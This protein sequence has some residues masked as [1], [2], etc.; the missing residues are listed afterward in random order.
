MELDKRKPNTSK[1]V[2]KRN[3][4]DKI[5]IMSGVFNGVTTGTPISMMIFNSDCISKDYDDIKDIYRPSH[6]DYTYQKKYD[7]RD[8]RGGGRSS[9][10]E[11]V[12]RVCAGAVAKKILDDFGVYIRAY[13]SSIGNVGIEELDFSYILQN[14]LRTPCRKTEQDILNLLDITIKNGNSIGGTIHCDILGMKAGIGEPVFDKLDAVLSKA[15]MSI[16]GTKG[17][18]FGKGF[19]S[20]RMY[21]S[22]YNDNFFS[23]EGTIYKSTNNSGGVLGGIS[24]GDTLSFNVAFKPTPSISL[25]QDTVNTNLEHR[26]ISIH[27][28][29]DPCIVPRAVIVVESM[30]AVAILDYLLVSLTNNIKT[31]KKLLS[32]IT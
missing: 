11:T 27:G 13:V 24:D 2:T 25:K 8:Y 30:V 16:G 17:I 28:R 29:H 5:N 10:R 18:E 32:L 26:Q 12:A 22:D 1:Y 19:E 9:G 7:V 6:A 14:Q 3:E 21:A 4:D 31:I 20:S 23:K 15:V